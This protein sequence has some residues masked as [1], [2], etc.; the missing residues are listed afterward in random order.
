MYVRVL[1]LPGPEWAYSGHRSPF[2]VT[3][4]DH[5]L[6]PEVLTYSWQGFERFFQVRNCHDH[7]ME[8]LEAAIGHWQDAQAALQVGDALPSVMD[9]ELTRRLESLIDEAYKLQD[10]CERL[11]LHQRAP[12]GSYL[13]SSLNDQWKHSRTCPNGEGGASLRNR[14]NSLLFTRNSPQP[15]LTSSRATG[16]LSSLDSFFSAQ[17]DVGYHWE[18]ALVDLSQLELYEAAA[19]VLVE[20]GIP[21]RALRTEMVGVTSDQE[22][23]I[24]V[25]CI[26]LGYRILFEDSGAASWFASRSRQIV[27]RLFCIADKDPTEFQSCFDIMM[28]YLSTEEGRQQM[29]AELR[30]RGLKAVTF[31][32]VILDYVMEAFEILEDPPSSI[33]AVA[34]NRWLSDRFKESA[35]SASIWSALQMKR[36]CLSSSTGYQAKFYDIL[37][38]FVPVVAWGFL[39][40]NEHLRHTCLIFKEEVMTYIRNIFSFHKVHYTTVEQVALDLWALAKT[41]YDS[42]CH[43]LAISPLPS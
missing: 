18:D 28:A 7:G 24:K 16:S 31:Y 14:T 42:L 9:V 26:R 23:L 41:R 2:V 13:I 32:D 38:H 43:R 40:P 21:F 30:E 39:G 20:D 3:S 22:F 37:N 1:L 36:K 6:T 15:T 17:S 5:E 29:N 27:S 10:V 34:R 12:A 25:H 4:N 33:V 11:F 8:A 35:L 19:K